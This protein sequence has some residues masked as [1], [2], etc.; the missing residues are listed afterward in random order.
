[1]AQSG[2]ISIIF[3]FDFKKALRVLAGRTN[4]GGFCPYD[5]VSAVPAFPDFDFRFFKNFGKLYVF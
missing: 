2:G 3:R 5:D 1:M 4:F